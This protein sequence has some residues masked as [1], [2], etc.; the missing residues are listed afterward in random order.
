MECEVIC[1]DLKS[2]RIKRFLDLPAGTFDWREFRLPLDFPAQSRSLAVRFK[3]WDP[4]GSIRLD[5]VSI[6]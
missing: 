5:D 3:L 4:A 2:C 6:R 1:N